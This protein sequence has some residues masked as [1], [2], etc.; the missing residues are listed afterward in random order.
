MSKA[1]QDAKPVEAVAEEEEYYEDAGE[2][3]P[4]DT[5]LANTDVV[6]KYK[7][8]ALWANETL[9]HIISLCVVGANVLTV[10]QTADELIKT[11]VNSMFKGVAEKGV[12]F[13]T[14]ISSNSCLCYQSEVPGE[15]NADRAIAVNDV[16]HIDLGV[17]VDGYSACVAHTL[18]V[19]AN[20]EL[21]PES[22][23]AQIISAAYKVLDTAVR[24]LRPGTDSYAVSH[25]I[26]K[27]AEH[28]GFA[29]VEGVLSHQLKR[30]IIDGFQCIPGRSAAEH[31]VH[32]CTIEPLTVWAMEVALTTGKGKL[33]EGDA[34]ANIFKQSIESTYTP[35]M[36]AAQEFS[37]EADSKFGMF[38]FA[39]RNIENKKARLGASELVKHGKLHRFA[40][41]YERDGEVVAHFK[42][43]VLVTDKKIERVTGVAPQKGAPAPKPF[44]SDELKAAAAQTF[45]LGEAKPKAAP[46]AAAAAA[47]PAAAAPAAAKK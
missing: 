15:E 33:R 7:K 42:L 45:T 2:E 18:H 1:A 39:M 41:L 40:P 44:E 11:K 31:R 19:T 9:Q 13:P 22:R 47:A 28:F 17:H 23:E 6:N 43:T 38:P 14:T 16:L 32:S 25:I 21:N 29:N 27:A 24:Q 35:K 8:A 34:K 37:K 26:E 12:A 30:F 3:V 20:G 36:A 5:T 46:A 4:E 10:C